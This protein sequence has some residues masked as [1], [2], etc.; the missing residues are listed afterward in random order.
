MNET[1]E[2]YLYYGEYGE[3]PEDYGEGGINGDGFIIRVGWELWHLTAKEIRSI[4][5]TPID[6]L[7]DRDAQ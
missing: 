4:L 3:R 1:D 6:E 7:A 2:P 5:D